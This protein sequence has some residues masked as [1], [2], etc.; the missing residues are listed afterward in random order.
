MLY[1][2]YPHPPHDRGI[3]GGCENRELDG[4]PRMIEKIGVCADCEVAFDDDGTTNNCVCPKC[5]G[6][7][8]TFYNLIT[9][10]KLNYFGKIHIIELDKLAK[11]VPLFCFEILFFHRPVPYSYRFCGKDCRLSLLYSVLTLRSGSECMKS[12]HRNRKL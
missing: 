8:Y 2:C 11:E 3:L 9:I 6:I 1:V 7:N 5:N 12:K 10:I 4:D